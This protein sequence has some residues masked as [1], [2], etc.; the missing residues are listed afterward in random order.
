MAG[1]ATD[2]VVRIEIEQPSSAADVRIVP[3]EERGAT[4]GFGLQ[5]V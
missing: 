1:Y 5:I 3:P 4:G 2:E